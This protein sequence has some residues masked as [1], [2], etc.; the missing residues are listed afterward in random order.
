MKRTIR[1]SATA[2]SVCASMPRNAVVRKKLPAHGKED[3]ESAR[4]QQ[5]QR[6]DG[7]QWTAIADQLADKSALS[8]DL[9]S[10][11]HAGTPH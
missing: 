1:Q 2:H 8:V 4:Q 11:P 9:L 3:R 10:A 6:C 5:H 7:Q